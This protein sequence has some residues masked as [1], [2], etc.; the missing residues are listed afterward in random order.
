MSGPNHNFHIPCACGTRRVYLRLK[1]GRKYRAIQE[2]VQR[3]S[4][5]SL[6]SGPKLPDRNAASAPSVLVA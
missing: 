3:A 2:N 1:P 4:I 6:A 5:L